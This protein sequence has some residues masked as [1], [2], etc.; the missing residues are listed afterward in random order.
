MFAVLAG[1]ML[2]CINNNSQ[3][4]VSVRALRRRDYQS[5]VPPIISLVPTALT[6]YIALWAPRGENTN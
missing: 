6:L 2:M 4:C 1:G 3:I 5:K